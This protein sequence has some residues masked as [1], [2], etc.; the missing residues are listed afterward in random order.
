MKSF[1]CFMAF[2]VLATVAVSP[3]ISIA[4][5]KIDA[6]P[7]TPS[8]K[9]DYPLDRSGIFIQSSD[10]IP[11]SGASPIK[12]RVK[13]GWADSLS[14]GAV[15]GI[16]LAEYEG[17]HAKV[18]VEPGQP[19]ICLCRMISLPGDPVLVRLHPKKDSR[20]LDGGRLRIL[21]SK[22]AEARQNDLVPVDVS[23]PEDNFWLVRSQQALPPGEYALMLGTQ[24]IFLYPFTVAAASSDSAAPS[25]PKH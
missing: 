14:Y 21:V 4:Q 22:M 17:L 11:L 18:Q 24:N 1:I 6:A 15:P 13:N 7:A 12:T 19:I 3:Q 16:I 9:A 23:K 8:F 5:N 10:W 2:S 20:E 25:A